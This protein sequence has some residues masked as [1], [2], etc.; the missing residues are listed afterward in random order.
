M[1]IPVR[2]DNSQR[3]FHLPDLLLLSAAITTAVLAPWRPTDSSGVDLVLVLALTL[4]F[5][6][7][8]RH[9]RPLTIAAAALATA[10]IAADPVLVGLAVGVALP[11]MFVPRHSR[12]C[13]PIKGLSGVGILNVLMRADYDARFGVSAAVGVVVIGFLTFRGF[14]VFR[15][16]HPRVL[17]AASAV[18]GLAMTVGLAGL[19]FS[20]RSSEAHLRTGNREARAGLAAL[21]TGDVPTARSHLEQALASMSQASRQLDSWATQ[22]SRLLPVVAQ[23]RNTI[24]DV[25]TSTTAA[26]DLINSDLARVDPELLRPVDGRFDVAAIT[27]LQIPMGR[28][29]STLDELRATVARQDS[30]WLIEP[31]RDYLDELIDDIDNYS[32][33]GQRT[34]EALQ[35]APPL[36]GADEPRTYFIAFVTPSEIRGSG[37]FMGN[38]AEFRV[39]D[40]QI[41]MTEFGRTNDLDDDAFDPRFVREPEDWVQAYGPYGFDTGL[42][43]SVIDRGWFSITLSPQFPSTAEVI[44]ELYPQS[45]G[46]Q[47]DGVFALDVDVLSTLLEFTG[48]IPV[49]G[50]AEPITAQNARQFLLF[51]QYREFDNPDRIDLI[52]EVAETALDR[53]LDGALPSPQVLG[54]RLSP[55]AGEGR[56]LAF[57]TRPDEQAFFQSLNLTGDVAQLG[58]TDTV[59]VSVNNGSANK[60]DYFLKGSVGYKLDLKEAKDE[61]RGMVTIQL[62]NNAPSSGLPNYVIGN[63]VDLPLGYSRL[64]VSALTRLPADQVRVDGRSVPFTQRIEAGLHVVDLFVDIP[65]GGTCTIT[66]DVSGSLGDT[67][68][69]TLATRTPLTAS[70]WTTNVRV[71]V[72]TQTL[73]DETRMK[74]GVQKWSVATSE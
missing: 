28:I 34:L 7:F 30:P 42:D 52:E 13:H 14:R 47:L 40:G 24:V 3:K 25:V 55:L 48:P 8:S 1:G 66:V 72:A 36:L 57:A 59:V 58:T 6:Y 61:G 74:H 44:S 45:G 67:S 39:I 22:L 19:F 2:G 65:P 70:V 62:A 35:M 73:I 43:G 41:R 38:W 68:E 4:F 15:R 23:H 37:G 51:D 26:L 49:T 31:A 32:A 56:I 11:G 20:A 9:A 27:D 17:F 53:L 69:Y 64:M 63:A 54:E 33:K 29:V 50:R 60:I 12:W 21:N 10:G 16:E 18:M 5:T 71:D 46:R